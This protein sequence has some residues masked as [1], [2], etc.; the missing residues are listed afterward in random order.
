[1]RWQ[2]LVKTEQDCLKKLLK[3]VKTARQISE[4]V[5]QRIPDRR[6]SDRK[7]LTAICVVQQRVDCETLGLGCVPLSSLCVSNV[8]VTVIF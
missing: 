1:M 7:R 2:H 3:T 5:R 6:T 8:S 4:L